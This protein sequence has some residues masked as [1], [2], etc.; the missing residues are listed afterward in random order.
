MV[1]L[2]APRLTTLCFPLLLSF[3]AHTHL[4]VNA[5]FGQ[6]TLRQELLND[7]AEQYRTNAERKKGQLR[8]E[9]TQGQRRRRAAARLSARSHAHIQA[10]S[11]YLQQG[12]HAPD[13]NV[14]IAEPTAMDED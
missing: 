13:S 12:T 14:S 10:R 2:L 6:D 8:Q 9:A 3:F 5:A 11:R 4:I 1:A 7:L